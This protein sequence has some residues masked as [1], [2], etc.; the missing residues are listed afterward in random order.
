MESKIDWNGL[1]LS[2]LVEYNVSAAQLIFL[3]HRENVTFRV[4]TR[5]NPNFATSEENDEQG[6]FLLRIHYPIA[7][8]SDRYAGKNFLV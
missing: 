6:L 5:N 1:A 2:V 8:L 7:E 3:S 4:D